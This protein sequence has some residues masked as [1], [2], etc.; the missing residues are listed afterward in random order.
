MHAL[1]P[2]AQLGLAERALDRL[3][4]IAFLAEAGDRVGVDVLEQKHAHAAARIGPAA[5][6]LLGVQHL[7]EGAGHRVGGGGHLGPGRGLDEGVEAVGRAR[8]ADL[9]VGPAV[10]DHHHLALEAQRPDRLHL[11]AVARQGQRG[12]HAGRRAV[13]AEHQPVGQHALGRHAELGHDR[14][15]ILMEAAGDDEQPL[16]RALDEVAVALDRGGH[17]LAQPLDQRLDVLAPGLQDFDAARQRLG[18]ADVAVHRLLGQGGDL[19]ELG[20]ALGVGLQHDLAEE[21]ERLDGDE[22]GI[23]IQD[24]DGRGHGAD[25]GRASPGGRRLTT[26]ARAA[27]VGGGDLARQ[28]QAASGLSVSLARARRRA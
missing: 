21:L 1:E 23:E 10:A 26:G 4:L 28:A 2:L 11:A 25:V 22:G 13:R 16:A 12:V 7:V 8:R 20:L 5:L 24:Q 18:E 14:V 27:D 19:G 3:D 15:D 6:Q 9:V 17:L